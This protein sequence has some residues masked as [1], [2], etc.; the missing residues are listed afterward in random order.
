MKIAQLFYVIFVTIILIGC[1]SSDETNS[2]NSCLNPPSWLI[3]SWARHYSNGTESYISNRVVITS[4]DVVYYNYNSDGTLA[5]TPMSVKNTYCNN[6]LT[7]VSEETTTNY[8]M[9]NYV[10]GSVIVRNYLHKQTNTTIILSNFLLDN[11]TIY[12]V[13]VKE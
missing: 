7:E 6:S 12:D 5:E 2:S 10:F 4:D 1:T 8:Y 3:G 9:W 13:Y 11:N